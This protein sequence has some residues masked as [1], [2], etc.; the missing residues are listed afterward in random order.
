MLEV[1][2]GLVIAVIAFGAGHFINSKPKAD[3]IIQVTIPEFVLPSIKV[4]LDHGGRMPAMV[5]S[6]LTEREKIAEAYEKKL[7]E[8]M[9][10][11]KTMTK[12]YKDLNTVALELMDNMLESGEMNDSSRVQS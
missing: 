4:E 5:Q 10:E 7:E 1:L 11:A 9:K 6:D 2:I 8:D 12:E 3:P